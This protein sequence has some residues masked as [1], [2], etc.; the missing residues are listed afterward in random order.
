MDSLSEDFQPKNFT[1][2]LADL[3]GDV[4][5]HDGTP[6]LKRH[7]VPTV[8]KQG[9][10]HGSGSL[11]KPEGSIRVMQW[12]VLADGMRNKILIHYGNK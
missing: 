7:F 1:D 11:E 3:R 4:A 9:S 6:L 5:Q 10:E 2:V 8:C 12:N